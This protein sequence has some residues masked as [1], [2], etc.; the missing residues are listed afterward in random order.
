MLKKCLN[1]IQSVAKK[2]KL[3]GFELANSEK[4]PKAPIFTTKSLV[5]DQSNFGDSLFSGEWLR[6]EN[7]LIKIM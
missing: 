7:T 6:T 1:I 2:L 5:R 3:T 4:C